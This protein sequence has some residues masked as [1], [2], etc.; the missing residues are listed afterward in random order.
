MLHAIWSRN[1]KGKPETVL[2]ITNQHCMRRMRKHGVSRL[3]FAQ[4]CRLSTT[5]FILHIYFYFLR[6]KWSDVHFISEKTAHLFIMIM[7]KQCVYVFVWTIYGAC[8]S[9][10]FTWCF[11]KQN[12]YKLL[13]VTNLFTSCRQDMF[14]LFVP[15]V[16]V[17]SLEQAVNELAKAMFF[18]V[19]NF[20]R[21]N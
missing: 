6:D 21:Q 15:I 8:C 4:D 12:Y 3:Y 7:K 18:F 1:W 19:L 14:A 5:K 13:L 16:V 11:H 17:K 10:K 20:T 2:T 9:N